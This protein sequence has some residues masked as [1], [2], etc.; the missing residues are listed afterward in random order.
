MRSGPPEH[1][2][3]PAQ[4]VGVSPGPRVPSP[5]DVMGTHFLC[6]PLCC[7]HPQCELALSQPAQSSHSCTPS[8]CPPPVPQ[9][10]TVRSTGSRGCPSAQDGSR[11]RTPFLGWGEPLCVAVIAPHSH[12]GAPASWHSPG[13]LLVPPARGQWPPSRA[14]LVR[15]EGWG[16]WNRGPFV[17]RRPSLLCMTCR[18]FLPCSRALGR[19]IH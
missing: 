9:H 10:P 18:L 17:L 13:G 7:H 1:H 5:L 6:C 3:P 14:P 16:N 2:L 12:P 15:R 19:A 8:L 11:S 4:D